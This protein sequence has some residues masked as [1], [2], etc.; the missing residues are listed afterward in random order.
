MCRK[1][2]KLNYDMLLII[3]HSQFQVFLNVKKV[4]HRINEVNI[5]ASIRTG[6]TC[7]ETLFQTLKKNIFSSPKWKTMRNIN[8]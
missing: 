5:K 7:S 1:R 3:S 4:H 2:K 8:K 6:I